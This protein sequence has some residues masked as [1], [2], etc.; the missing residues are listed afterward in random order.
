MKPSNEIH[1]IKVP[2]YTAGKLYGWSGKPIGLGVN[3]SLLDGEGVLRVRVGDNSQVWV[4]DKEIA[5]E[6]IKRFNST[7]NA[8]GTMLGVVAWYM[9]EKED[10]IADHQKSLFS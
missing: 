6:F 5:I 8:R 4:I 10:D 9:F 7:F 3:L 2:F 1:T